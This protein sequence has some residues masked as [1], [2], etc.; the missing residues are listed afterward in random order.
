MKSLSPLEYEVFFALI[1]LRQKGVNA[2][3]FK[4]L[5]GEVNRRRKSEREKELTVQHIHYY[6]KR[7]TMR[8]FIRKKNT[9][10]E[11]YYSLKH[12]VW[13]INQK[14]P[15]CI[16]ITSDRTILLPC[17]RIKECTFSPSEAC[18]LTQFNPHLI[19]Q[20]IEKMVS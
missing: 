5:C 14:P 6:V 12:G 13:K 17:T 19:M 16:K 7:L 2:A 10:G 1:Q 18:L 20:K 3:L 4:D 11:A 15:L 8:P 9:H